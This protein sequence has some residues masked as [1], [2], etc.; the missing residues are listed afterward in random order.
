MRDPSQFPEPERYLPERW[1]R[2]NPLQHQAHPFASII[3][4][5]GPRSCI[6]RRFAELE[7]YI[8]AIKLL[9]KYKLEYHHQPIGCVTE[10]VNKPDNKIKLRLIPRN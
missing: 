5:H 8:L 3:F 10:F 6:G 4:S 1:L 7:C 9:Q 2:G